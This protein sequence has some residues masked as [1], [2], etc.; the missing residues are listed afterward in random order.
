MR[1]VLER[2]HPTAGQSSLSCGNFTSL[3]YDRRPTAHWSRAAFLCHPPAAS[4]RQVSLTRAQGRRLGRAA[5]QDDDVGGAK[6]TQNRTSSGKNRGDSASSAVSLP[7]ERM[8]R[9]GGRDYGEVQGRERAAGIPR[10]HRISSSVAVCF[11]CLC[12]RTT[13]EVEPPTADGRA[14]ARRRLPRT[15]SP[16]SSRRQVVLFFP[17]R[18]F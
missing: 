17:R 3:H 16:S 13:A 9:A 1:L 5:E 14:G 7:Q 18:A 8:L 2:N 4:A 12:M 15:S 6:E 11:C 10:H